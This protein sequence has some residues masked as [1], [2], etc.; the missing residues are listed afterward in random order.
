MFYLVAI[1][2]TVAW[3]MLCI[4][5]NYVETKSPIAHKYLNHGKQSVPNI[6]CYKLKNLSLKYIVIT[7]ERTYSTQP[8]S[9]LPAK[10]YE[11]V[12]TLKNSIVKENKG[13][14][15]FYMWTNKITGDIYIGQSK[16]LA[17]RFNKYFSISYLKSKE[18]LI[19]SR[20]FIK[21]GYANFSLTILE[22][23]D[24]SEL[25]K[26]EQYYFNKLGPKYNILKIAGS[27]LG[28]TL[29]EDTK[30]KISKALKGVYA[31]KKS[32]WFGKSF[33]EE[34]KLLMSSQRSWEKNSMFGKTH[35]EKSK[36]IMKQKALGRKHSEETKLKMSAKHGNP[37]NVY[38]KCSSEGFK[39]IGSFVSARRAAKFLGMSHSTINIYVNSGAIFKDRYKFSI[40]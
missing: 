29:S 7:T 3:I 23:C 28:H 14:S 20:A 15:G 11:D 16:N 37:V 12:E 40:K 4:V 33:S 13:F 38:E 17:L 35:S 22:Y 10:F 9:N 36:E 2:F 26:R 19:I 8:V 30:A 6:K 34:T 21:Y 39:L 27:S 32:Y 18:S 25:Q 1:L 31:G 24:I 5:R